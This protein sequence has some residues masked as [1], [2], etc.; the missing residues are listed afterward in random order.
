MITTYEIFF[1]QGKV[2]ARFLYLLPFYFTLFVIPF[3]VLDLDLSRTNLL[4]DINE[5]TKIMT[6][7]SRLD[8]LYTQFRVLVTYLRL[9][10]FPINQNLDYDFPIYTSFFD[11]EVMLSFVFLIALVALATYL[12]YRSR[13]QGRI[14]RLISFCI[15]W[16]F[17]TLSI[18]SSIIPIADVMFEHRLYLPSTGIFIAAVCSIFYFVHRYAQSEKIVYATVGVLFFIN[19]ILASA[20]F[21]R[22]IIW[23][24]EIKLWNDVVQKSPRKARGYNN[25]GFAYEKKGFYKEAFENYQKAITIDPKFDDAYYNRANTYSKIGLYNQALVNY[26]Q[27]IMINPLHAQA[28]NNRG[29]V[30]SLIGGIDASIEDFSQSIIINP[31]FSEAYFNRALSYRDKGIVDVFD[32]QVACKLGHRKSCETLNK[33]P[34]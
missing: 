17:I 21:A 2:K 26:S 13:N 24:D 27:A 3:S 10:F 23:N 30:Y 8:Y 32:L 28:Y 33:T 31:N 19:I 29:V 18:E 25:L 12:Y 7:M 9:I 22:S 1:F 4:S 34:L 16:F 11:S 15:F 5:S 20:T 14:F 6:P